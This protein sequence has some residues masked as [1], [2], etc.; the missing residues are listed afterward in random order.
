MTVHQSTDRRGLRVLSYDEC[1]LLLRTAVVGRLG[2]IHHSEP[3]ILPVTLGMD[4]TAPVFRTTWGSKFDA[5]H[6]LGLVVLE[7]DALNP[8]LGRAWSVVVKGT[9]SVEYSDAVIA[10][11]ESL[12]IPSWLRDDTETFW[13][14]V[15]PE[16]VT[17]RELTLP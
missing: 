8:A 1:V 7:I 13:I 11:L 6:G 5:V 14:R 3:E 4:G 15:L 17:G 10:R 16:S 9:A 2:F 12:G